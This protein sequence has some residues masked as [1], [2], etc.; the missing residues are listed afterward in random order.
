MCICLSLF[1]F[2]FAAADR[3]SAQ[4]PVI[5]DSRLYVLQDTLMSDVHM[6]SL[7]TPRALDAIVS[8]MKTSIILEFQVVPRRGRSRT[9]LKNLKLQHDIWEGRYEIIR[10]ADPPDTLRTREFAEVQRFCSQ[11]RSISLGAIEE[12]D[13]PLVVLLRIAV[14]PISVEQE[15]RTRRWLQF[16]KRGSILELFVSLD[17]PFDR[18]SWLEIGRLTAEPAP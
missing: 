14:N 7:F 1:F 4:Q 8:G 13:R 11:H 10:Q 3:V 5:R 16:L 9:H 15:Q 12:S 6:D 17:R 18:T 2:V